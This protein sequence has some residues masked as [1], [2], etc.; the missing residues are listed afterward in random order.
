MCKYGA[1]RTNKN[2]VVQCDAIN[3]GLPTYIWKIRLS[4]LVYIIAVVTTIGWLLFMVFCGAGLVALP[5]DMIR[6]FLGRPRACITKSE[7]MTRAKALGNKAKGIMESAAKLR[8]EDREVGRGRKWR[9][10]YRLLNQEVLVLE[11]E[12][13]QLDLVYPQSTDP[14]Y[15]WAVTVIIFYLKLLFGVVGVGLSICWLLQ[16]L[17]YIFVYPPVTPF[18]NTLFTDLDNAFPL[19]GTV[20]FG[21]FCFYLIACVIK[22]A[23]KVGL[24]LVVF[25]VHPMKVGAT[26]MSSFLF[27][28]ALVLLATQAAIQFCAQAFELYANN[29]AIQKI[30]GGQIDYVMGLK[31]LYRLHVFYYSLYACVGIT[32]IYLIVRGPDRWKR[33]KVEDAYVV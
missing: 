8:K 17:L 18:L 22:G 5:L 26:L 33:Y 3:G 9:Q 1:M 28:V 2:G 25:T 6:E 12:E 23:T 19:F 15:A 20:A 14:D 27:N 31:Y 11:E 10:N 24:N 32:A 30:W 13:K 21:I 29:S 7:Y 16:I 4:F